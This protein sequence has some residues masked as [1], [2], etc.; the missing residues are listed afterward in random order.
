MTTITI[1]ARDLQRDDRFDFCGRP[2]VVDFISDAPAS[3]GIY[4][5]TEGGDG[6]VWVTPDTLVTVD[7][8]DPDADLIER[9]ARALTGADGTAATDYL[10]DSQRKYWSKL[11]RAALAVVRADQ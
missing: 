10:T 11:A 5:S 3:T 6:T 4:F 7:R 2:S 9:I 8:P 1:P